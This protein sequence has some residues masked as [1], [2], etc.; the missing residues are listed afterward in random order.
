MSQF[1]YYT[2]KSIEENNNVIG[3]VMFG[4]KQP[5]NSGAQHFCADSNR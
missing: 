5:T 3:F 4:S 2:E 1:V